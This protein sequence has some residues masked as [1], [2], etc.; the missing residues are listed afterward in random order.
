MESRPAVDQLQRG[1]CS[2]EADQ[3]TEH[4]ERGIVALRNRMTLILADEVFQR[5]LCGIYVVAQ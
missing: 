3:D 5:H 2:D 4:D 1:A